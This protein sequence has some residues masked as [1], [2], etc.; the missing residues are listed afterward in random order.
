LVTDKSAESATTTLAVALLLFGLGSVVGVA[1][2]ASVSL[3]VVP[4]VVVGLTV[5]TKVIV[6][7]ALAARLAILQV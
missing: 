2:T 6:A 3:I 4:E 1:L 7:L 5:T